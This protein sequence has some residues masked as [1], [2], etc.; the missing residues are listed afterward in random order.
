MRRSRS[1]AGVLRTIEP[2]GHVLGDGHVREERVVLEDGIH[3]P[4]EGWDA[5]DVLPVQQDAALAGQLEAGDHAQRRRLPRS[6]RTQHGEELAVADLQID[7]GDRLDVT[8]ALDE[9]LERDRR[10]AL[11]R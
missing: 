2:V 10:G 11:R 8:E 6:G 4:V 1:G 5:R 9:V 3:V 7:A